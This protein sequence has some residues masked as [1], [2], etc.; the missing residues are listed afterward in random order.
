MAADFARLANL[1]R[2]SADSLFAIAPNNSALRTLES[3]KTKIDLLVGVVD[4][5]LS[6]N[7]QHAVKVTRFPVES[8]ATLGD[9]AVK[10][11]ARLTITGWTSDLYPSDPA[12]IGQQDRPAQAWAAILKLASDRQ[13]LT[14]FTILG[15][16]E[17]M[18]ITG[19]NAPVS[20]ATARGLLFTLDFEEV[21]TASLQRVEFTIPIRPT[22]G[23]PAADRVPPAGGA[24]DELAQGP[25]TYSP[26]VEEVLNSADP[27][28]FLGEGVEV[29]RS[30]AENVIEKG[31]EGDVGGAFDA[32]GTG[33]SRVGELKDQA[34]SGVGNV[35]GGL[36]G[37]DDDG[38]P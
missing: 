20:S 26:T 9:H 22:T 34:I 38:A 27:F 24:D 18:V 36:F 33:V 28:A 3:R 13:P 19:V 6:E 35:L 1:A 12:H 16:Y 37:D 23:G 30:T 29:I 5:Y 10:E 15:M 21:L 14:V 32:F 17:N 2:D 8:G 25:T 11:P 7:H 4:G 31:K